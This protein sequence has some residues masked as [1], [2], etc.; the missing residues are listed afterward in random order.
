MEQLGGG[1]AA[2]P[3]QKPPPQLEQLDDAEEDEDEEEEEKAARKLWLAALARR[4][5]DTPVLLQEPLL[6]LEEEAAT[7]RRLV[8]A[9]L[10]VM[11]ARAGQQHLDLAGISATFDVDAPEVLQFMQD[12][13]VQLSEAV[14]N[15]TDEMVRARI[16]EGYEEQLGPA[17][18]RERLQTAFEE[19]REDWQLDRIARTESHH[20]Q[21]GAG[22]EAS[23]QA[24]V[25]FK[26]W[27]TVRDHR[28]RGLEPEDQADHAGMEDLGPV[29]LEAAFVD[30]R[31]GAQL[32]YP[33]DRSGAV[34]GADTIN[35][36]CSWIADQSHLDRELQAAHGRRKAP[37][38]DEVWWAKARRR[39]DME[40]ELRRLIKKQLLDMERRALRAFTEQLGQRRAGGA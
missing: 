37:T 25:E 2:R 39:D 6:D 30:P 13:L 31:S 12:M 26:R 24:G 33:G 22:W 1:G 28:V 27:L 20:A 19:R 36:R 29:P 9:K 38:L 16:A 7:F 34:S 21:E 18:M 14:V 17:D 10:R 4:K 11:I 35:C 23:R 3:G 8:Q 32:M 40:L 5:Q 15:N